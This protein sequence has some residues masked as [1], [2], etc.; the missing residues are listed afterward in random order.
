MAR[1]RLQNNTF[2]TKIPLAKPDR[3]ASEAGK[4]TLLEIAA[5]RGLL[6]KNEESSMNEAD[7]GSGADLET[8]IGRLGEAIVSSISLT[9]LHFTFDVLVQHQYA[10]ALS[11]RNIV[12]RSMQA[13]GGQSDFCYSLAWPP[14]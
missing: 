10:V 7:V 11:W 13:F 14:N 9:M 2:S 12:N 8:P 3:S 5:Q 4:A 1:Q 6:K